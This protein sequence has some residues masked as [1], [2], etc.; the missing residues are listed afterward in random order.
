MQRTRQVGVIVLALI[1]AAC[2]RPSPAE[3]TPSGPATAVIAGLAART[4]G[5]PVPAPAP[6]RLAAPTAAPPTHAATASALPAERGGALPADPDA[7][8]AQLIAEVNRV[9]VGA[10]LPPY[11]ANAE[12]GAAARAHSCDLAAHHTIAHIS[13]DGRTLAERLAGSTPPWEWPSESIAAGF[14]DPIQVVA[15]W[16]DEPPEGWHRR[17]ILDTEQREIGAGYCYTSDDPS[18]NYH[19]WTADFS[20]RG[21]QN[22]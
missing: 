21:P 7:L 14:D 15:V 10:G 8:E 6:L 16:M 13:S 1:C 12:L 22:Q 17:N 11:L 18:G 9:R 3:P 2:G 20:R 4:P 5:A 19:Y